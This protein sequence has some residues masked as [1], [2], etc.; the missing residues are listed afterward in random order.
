MEPDDLSEQHE[1]P[2]PSERDFRNFVTRLLRVPKRE[3]DERERA[4]DKRQ[5]RI[6]PEP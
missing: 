2:S 6:K 5:S 1:Q 4:R 3:I